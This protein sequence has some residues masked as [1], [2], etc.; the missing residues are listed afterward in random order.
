MGLQTYIAKAPK[1]NHY[2]LISTKDIFFVFVCFTSCFVFSIAVLPRSPRV[3]YYHLL[4]RQET[5]IPGLTPALFEE[6]L[7]NFCV[8]RG[9]KS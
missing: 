8:H 2:S 1:G 4:L 3:V 6:D 9:Q 5:R 7:G